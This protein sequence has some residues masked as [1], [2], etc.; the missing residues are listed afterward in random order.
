MASYTWSVPR[1]G[2]FPFPRMRTRAVGVLK[3]GDLPNHVPV[4]RINTHSI[5]SR[6]ETTMFRDGYGL[7]EVKERG[8]WE[9]DFFHGYLRY[10]AHTMRGVGKRMGVST[11]LFGL[12]K[13]QHRQTRA[14]SFCIGC[15][16]GIRNRK[17]H[18]APL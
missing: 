13:L 10:G 1:I 7:L 8:R 6:G 17:P 2:E 12:A 14:A 9:S 5:R 3:F 11:G 16:G 15:K 18:S 4:G